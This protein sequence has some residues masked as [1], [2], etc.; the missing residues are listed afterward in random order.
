[1]ITKHL[2]FDCKLKFDGRKDNLD[3]KWNKYKCQ[4][5]CK[6]SDK[7]SLMQRKLCLK[8]IFVLVHMHAVLIDI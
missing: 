1:M 5:E 8:I 4:G 2:S 3:Q 6:T 7:T